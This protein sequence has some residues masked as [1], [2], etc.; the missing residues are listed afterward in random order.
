M[1]E[2]KTPEFKISI[3]KERHEHDIHEA[4]KDL[5]FEKLNQRVTIISILI[6]CIIVIVFIVSYLDIKNKITGVHDSGSMEVSNLSRNLDKRTSELSSQYSDLKTS[7]E[8]KTA[9]LKTEFHNSAKEIREAK[10][11][12]SD[13]AITV[14]EIKKQISVIRTAV[15][16]I[17]INV[18]GVETGLT[19]KI[20]DINKG[21]GKI[22]NNIIKLQSDIA[23]ISVSKAD[24]K[25]IDV[26]LRNEQK[27][28]QNELNSLA[29]DIENKME[30][31]RRQIAEVE[32]KIPKTGYTAQP[33]VSK[34]A[35][36]QP[37]KIVEQDLK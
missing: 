29:G 26:Y 4:K 6:P 33:A 37:G 31:I 36:S 32:R 34:G 24:K 1:D 12:K 7:F 35:V 11:D 20:A 17:S 23:G 15:S 30:S 19:Q 9:A 21:I 28:Y 18:K 2:K 16:A 5:R 8:N 25:D 3:D 10:A 22:E 27:R 14:D 13:V